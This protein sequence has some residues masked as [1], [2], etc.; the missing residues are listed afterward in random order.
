M[1]R[2]LEILKRGAQYG[3]GFTCSLGLRLKLLLLR[4]LLSPERSIDFPRYHISF[5][6]LNGNRIDLLSLGF[7]YRD[8]DGQSKRPIVT[9]RVIPSR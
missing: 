7:P 3:T 9:V 5:S 2:C 1:F 6:H 4:D 8:G